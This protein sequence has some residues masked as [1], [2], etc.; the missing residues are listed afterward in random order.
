MVSVPVAAMGAWFLLPASSPSPASRSGASSAGAADTRGDATAEAPSLPAEPQPTALVES[1]DYNF[2]A[3]DSLQRGEHAFVIRN[4][5]NAPLQL[6]DGGTTCKCTLTDLPAAPIPPGGEGRVTLNWL[7]TPASKFYSQTATVLTNDPRNRE[8]LLRVFGT[9]RNRV[10]VEPASVV[11]PKVEP[12]KSSTS[13]VFVFSELWPRF[14]LRDVACSLPGFQC[15]VA[16]VAPPAESGLKEGAC[17]R[18]RVTTP[19]D[20]QRG[21]FQGIVSFRVV[22]DAPGA[23]SQMCEVTVSGRVIRRLSVYGGAINALGEVSLGTIEGGRDHEVSLLMKVRDADKSLPIQRIDVRPEFVEVKVD[24]DSPDAAERGLYRLRIRVPADAPPC[25]YL[26][27]QPGTLH[28][29]I[30]HPRIPELSLTLH[31]AVVEDSQANSSAP[32]KEGKSRG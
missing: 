11:F 24:A 8:L 26:G 5:G 28:L 15:D 12:D 2:G 27:E 1:A 16:P 13:E 3:M 10:V 20:L 18:L 19:A 25:E 22:P 32:A 31:F 7:T 23:K 6:Q 9:V 4:I 30:D 17:Y 21:P 14:E 29:A